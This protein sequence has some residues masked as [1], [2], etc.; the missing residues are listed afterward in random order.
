MLKKILNLEHAQR[1]SK[2]EQKLIKG[3]IPDCWIYAIEAGCVL[4]SVGETCPI[5]KTPGICDSNR[6]C[7]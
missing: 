4:I 2:N 1:I 6:L 3:G 7:C 5:D